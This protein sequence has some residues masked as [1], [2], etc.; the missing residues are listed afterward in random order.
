MLLNK[1]SLDNMNYKLNKEFS[2]HNRLH[3]EFKKWIKNNNYSIEDLCI[4]GSA[5]LSAYGL[6][7]ARDL[8]YISNPNIK[9]TLRLKEISNSNTS[10]KNYFKNIFELIY[11]PNNFF[12]FK[13]LKY[14]SLDKLK[15]KKKLRKETK[16]IEDLKLINCL[17]KKNLYLPSF[18]IL[19]LLNYFFLKNKF[20]FFLL[21]LRFFLYK[22]IY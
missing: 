15:F 16:D 11:N 10:N 5:V 14:L 4:E 2:W 20:K 6:R 12:Y 17:K 9:K 21:K 7:E 1:N 18:N 8:D 19:D 13:G 3:N 22:L